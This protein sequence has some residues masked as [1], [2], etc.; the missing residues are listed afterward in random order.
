MMRGR[1]R[2]VLI[3]ILG[4]RAEDPAF[5]FRDGRRLGW[6]NPGFQAQGLE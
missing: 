5:R 4:L 1:S 6:L 2:C 3:V